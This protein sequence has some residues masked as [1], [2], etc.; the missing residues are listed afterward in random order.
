MGSRI[1]INGIGRLAVAGNF[2]T[3]RA[4]AV[5]VVCLGLCSGC[6]SAVSSQYGITQVDGLGVVAASRSSDGAAV[7]GVTTV[8]D[9]G[10]WTLVIR[11]YKAFP[12]VWPADSTWDGTDHRAVRLATGTVIHSGETLVGGGG[13]TEGVP[14]STRSID[15]SVTCLGQ[16]SLTYLT[17]GDPAQIT[18]RA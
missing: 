13:F 2:T 3:R 10:C 18:S 6:K 11:G 4:M 12:V 9:R 5:A 7:Q 15:P 14:R 17:L 8:D 16:G 1:Y